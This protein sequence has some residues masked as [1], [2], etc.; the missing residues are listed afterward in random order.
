MTPHTHTTVVPGCFRCDLGS[1]EVQSATEHVLARR[2]PVCGDLYAWHS[3]EG[4][5]ECLETVGGDE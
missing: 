3:F 4:L 5:A 1:D 2:C